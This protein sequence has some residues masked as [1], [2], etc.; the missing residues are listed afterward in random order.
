MHGD[1]LGKL[2]A[3]AQRLQRSGQTSPSAVYWSQALTLL[4]PDSKQAAWVREQSNLL[5]AEG[6]AAESTDASKGRDWVRRFGPFGPVLLVLAKAKGLLFAV[7]KLKFLFSLLSFVAV[8]WALFGWRFGVGFAASILI[9]EMGHYVDI[10]RRGLP[11]EMP[12]FLPGLGAYVK[13]QALGV[14][15]RQRAEVSLAGPL[16][17]GLAAAG[18]YF[19]YQRTR[20][21]LWSALGHT[22]AVLNVLNLIPIWVLDGAQAATALGRTERAALLAATL[23]IWAYT[24]ENI[25]F[26]VAAGLVYRLFTRDLP[27]QPSW[28]VF[29]YYAAV[30]A[31]L[32]MLLRALPR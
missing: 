29:A 2:V 32:G 31:A 4:P 11:A 10:R 5:Q 19:A 9:H 3:E 26:F 16:A 15:L 1:Q 7:F 12:V 20:N 13:W 18:C 24:G 8:Y 22:G 6:N 28:N 21:P 27:L 25:Y 23:L 30:L 14:T 17:G